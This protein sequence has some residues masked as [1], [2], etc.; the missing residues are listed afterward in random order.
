MEGEISD[1]YMAKELTKWGEVD[2]ETRKWGRSCGGLENV[3]LKGL[4]AARQ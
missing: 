1:T 2:Q 4:P 3:A